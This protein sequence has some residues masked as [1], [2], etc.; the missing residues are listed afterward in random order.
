MELK[1]TGFDWLIEQSTTLREGCIGG[2]RELALQ[3]PAGL[4]P[5]AQGLID[6]VAFDVMSS[7][8]G[9]S[10]TWD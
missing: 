7:P 6:V 5:A 10:S 4:Q 9:S 8:D 3:L 1:Q 2:L